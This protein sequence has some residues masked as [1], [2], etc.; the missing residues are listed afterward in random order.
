M[1]PYERL[2]TSGFNP[3]LSVAKTN[4]TQ[5][6]AINDPKIQDDHINKYEIKSKLLEIKVLPIGK[7]DNYP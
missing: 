3:K 2:R 7:T 4:G 5:K 6:E 1:G